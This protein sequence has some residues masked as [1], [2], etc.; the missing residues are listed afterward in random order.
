MPASRNEAAARTLLSFCGV[1]AVWYAPAAADVRVGA[2]GRALKNRCVTCRSLSRVTTTAAAP[3]VYA[4][5]R[6]GAWLSKA[7]VEHP[8]TR[9]K[10]RQLSGNIELVEV[11]NWRLPGDFAAPRCENSPG[12][13]V[14]V[15]LRFG[16]A[17]VDLEVGVKR[18]A[19]RVSGPGAFSR[20]VG[21]FRACRMEFLSSVAQKTCRQ[22]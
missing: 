15:S 1:A 8:M 6:V 16:I 7:L 3:A 18:P 9:F 14:G 12:E 13:L 22:R 21:W 5:E 11:E 20:F 2:F 10:E 19:I 4:N 17:P